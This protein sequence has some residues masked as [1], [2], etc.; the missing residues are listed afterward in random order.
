MYNLCTTV[1]GFRDCY[2]PYRLIRSTSCSSLQSFVFRRKGIRL[3]YVYEVHV[4]KPSRIIYGLFYDFLVVDNH[5]EL[6]REGRW[7]S[8]FS[9]F[10]EDWR[11]A[12]S[13]RVGHPFSSIRGRSVQLSNKVYVLICVW[14]LVSFYP[15]LSIDC[16]RTALYD[17]LRL[18]P[19]RCVYEQCLIAYSQLLAFVLAFVLCH[20]KV[21][22]LY[23]WTWSC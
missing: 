14:R 16:V 8:W 2:S 15:I 12:E 18:S 5:K 7:C 1:R 11:S 22:R 9:W 3:Q 13:S 10:H 23:D 4:L 6:Y 20:V 19:M 21:I 17:V